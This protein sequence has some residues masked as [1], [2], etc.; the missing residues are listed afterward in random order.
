MSGRWSR[1][2]TVHL[3][4]VKHVRHGLHTQG[5]TIRSLTLACTT[6]R[7]LAANTATR[8]TWTPRRRLLRA[9]ACWLPHDGWCAKAYLQVAVVLATG[10]TDRSCSGAVRAL[11]KRT[12][13][14][15][16]WSAR[17]RCAQDLS[18]AACLTPVGCSSYQLLS[19]RTRRGSGESPSLHKMATC[20]VGPAPSQ[21]TVASPA[22]LTTCG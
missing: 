18:F 21:H 12:S 17:S 13:S 5:C 14:K 1:C 4:L 9:P 15:R 3:F 22:Y 6:S 8:P 7:F 2:A 11:G 20:C 19:L 16:R 10:P